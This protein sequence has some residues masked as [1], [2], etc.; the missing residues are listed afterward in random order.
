MQIKTF[1]MNRSIA[2][3]C[4]EF[5]PHQSQV[6]RYENQSKLI[7]EGDSD[8]QKFTLHSIGS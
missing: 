1:Q 7:T 8:S 4:S 5:G 2:L 6:N 3:I